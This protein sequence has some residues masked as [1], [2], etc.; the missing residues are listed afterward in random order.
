ME[1]NSLSQKVPPYSEEAESAVLG[2]LL[3][4][5]SL[6]ALDTARMYIRGSDFFLI[7]HQNIFQAIES[8]EKKGSGIDVLTVIEELKSQG[9]LEKAG[10][11]SYVN[12]LVNSFHTIGNIEYYARIVQESSIRR[13]LLGIGSDIQIQAYNKA[14]DT[15]EILEDLERQVF[16][17]N[18]KRSVDS[19]QRIS[20]LIKTAVDAIEE[21]S[22]NKKS[23]TGIPSGFPELDDMTSGFQDSEM[24]VIG[25]RPSVGKTALAM[26]MA[27]NMSIQKNIK[28][29]FF[30]LEMSHSSVTERLIAQEGNINSK[31]IKSGLMKKQDMLLVTEVASK[32]YEAPMWIDDTPNMKLLDLRAQAR[33]MVSKYGVQIIFIDYLGLITFED[34]KI[35]RHEQMAEVSRSLKAL[36]RELKI[37]VIALSQVGRQVEGKE[38]ALSDLRESGA[39]EQDAD[40]VLFLHRE[41]KTE[42]EADPAASR[43]IETK[44][45]MAKNR[46]GP[47]G[48][49]KLMF[50]PQYTKFVPLSR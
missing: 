14:R 17:I 8:L 48:Y 1:P 35:P 4:N 34:K 16:E 30:S 2:V 12:S 37:P 6:D 11:V 24:I 46:N 7:S 21:R 18:D 32:I 26:T 9:L 23:C 45:I 41:R 5:F 29:G 25:A 15:S 43:N 50:M 31:K 44:L 38:P 27:A 33:R 42:D 40:M 49:V 10:G 3:I 22:K 36:A 47:I 19:T 28:C 39:I 13:R 20:E